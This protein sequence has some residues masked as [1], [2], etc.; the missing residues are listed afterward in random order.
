MSD[1]VKHERLSH[2]NA[3]N[4]RADGVSHPLFS[5]S[6]FFDPRDLVLVKYEMIRAV[7]VEQLTVAQVALQFGFSRSGY[8]KVLASFQCKGL[9]GLSRSTPGPRKAHKLDDDVMAMIEDELSEDNTLTSTQLAALL[10][11][12]H[13]LAVHPRS[14]ER[15][16]ARRKKKR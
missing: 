7:R 1:G 2:D 15:A 9:A 8:Y 11:Q 6:E 3:L 12:R 5:H 10:V 4:L 16:L 14:I 13:T